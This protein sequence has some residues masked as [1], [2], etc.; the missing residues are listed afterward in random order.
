MKFAYLIVQVPVILHYHLNQDS[1]APWQ[2]TPLNI[3]NIHNINLI[4]ATPP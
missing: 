3:T 1:K 2:H 4:P